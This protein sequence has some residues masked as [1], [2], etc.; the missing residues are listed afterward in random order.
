MGLRMGAVRA[1]FLA[2][3][4]SS[5]R[6]SRSSFCAF[7]LA[8]VAS[9]GSW[10]LGFVTCFVDFGGGG[11]L[12]GR[13]ASLSDPPASCIRLSRSSF[14]AFSLAAVASPGSWKLGTV[15]GFEDLG[16]G[17]ILIGRCFGTTTP[18]ASRLKRSSF[19]ALS[20]AAT[21][22]LD[23]WNAGFVGALPLGGGGGVGKDKLIGR[24]LDA[25]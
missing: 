3:S 23:N 6:L 5:I 20:F 4:A 8:A 16:G 1:A 18:S 15:G 12:I 14:W 24:R 22:S 21:L 13:V 17:G 25:R 2:A 10:K 11:M 19:C 7:S 9:P